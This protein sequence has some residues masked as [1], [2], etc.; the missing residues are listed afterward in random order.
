V[1]Y[2]D[3][4]LWIEVDN[5]TK[6]GMSGWPIIDEAG[7]AIGVVCSGEESDRRSGPTVQCRLMHSLPRW[8]DIG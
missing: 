8:F 2:N 5:V 3:G 1:W 6:G 7:N 4:P